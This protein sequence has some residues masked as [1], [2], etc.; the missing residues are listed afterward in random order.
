MDGA[1]L[2]RCVKERYPRVM[3]VILS[4]Q[5]EVGAALRAASV[6]HQF[7]TKPCDMPTVVETLE[8]A[9]RVQATLHNERVL[10]AVGSLET[11]PAMPSTCRA[12]C[13]LIESEDSTMVEIAALVEKDV[14][15]VAKL[16][17]LG[18]SPFFGMRRRP[19]NVHDA[20]TYL[21]VQVLRD[22]VLSVG[23]F[24]AFS[25]PGH[26]QLARYL[27][28]LQVDSMRKACLAKAIA[29]AALGE[30]AFTAGLL[31]DVGKLAWLWT[32]PE[33]FHEVR[34]LEKSTGRPAHEVEHE[35]VGFTHADV[36]GM[37]AGLWGFSA[38]VVEA[39]AHHCDAPG[40]PRR[41]FGVLDAVFVAGAVDAGAEAPP[42]GYLERLGVAERWPAWR[43]L[44]TLQRTP[45]GA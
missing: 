17:Q 45:S 24:T 16:M 33:S 41:T 3:R 25:S 44:A 14:A 19:N 30:Q 11:L 43:A 38:A 42:E 37:V 34:A 28:A 20:V 7:L 18:N 2:L 15:M 21:G 36:G 39:V 4:G 40:V 31:Q 10:A 1:A 26:P 5:T 8:S 22:L 35:L 23:I 27:E 13:E 32:M 6:A 12:L 9:R 29:P